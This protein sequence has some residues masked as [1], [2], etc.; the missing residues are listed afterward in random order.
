M[1]KLVA[2]LHVLDVRVIFPF[3]VIDV[4]SVVARIL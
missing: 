3:S 2:L 1:Q 4:Y